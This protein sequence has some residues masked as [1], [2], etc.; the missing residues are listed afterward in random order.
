MDRFLAGNSLLMAGPSDLP[1]LPLPLLPLPVS[2]VLPPEPV[3]DHSPVVPPPSRA[4]V[5][6]DLSREG[7]LM[8][9]RVHRLWGM[10]P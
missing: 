5:L 2:G 8:C 4:S 1:L 7:P 9:I 6:P 3:A 10:L